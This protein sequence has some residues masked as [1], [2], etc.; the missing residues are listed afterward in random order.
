MSTEQLQSHATSPTRTRRWHTIAQVAEELAVA[1][2]TVHTWV[3]SGQ[4]RARD[5]SVH[6]PSGRRRQWRVSDQALRQ[7]L[8]SR[9]STGLPGPL[10]PVPGPRR[11]DRA[12]RTPTQPEQAAAE[13]F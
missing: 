9:D 6:G 7:F 4:L 13:R 1:L 12:G 11:R 10:P 8:D 3:K 5:V 2:S